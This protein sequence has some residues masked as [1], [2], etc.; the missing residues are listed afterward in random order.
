MNYPGDHRKV[1]NCTGCHTTNTEA[2]TWRS[3]TYKPF[4]AGCHA[5]DY[6][7]G[8]HKKVDNPKILYT[9]GELK[10]C[11]GA[12][13]TYTDNTLSVIKKRR[14]GKHLPSKGGW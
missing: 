3:P 11:S 5:K 4:C 12:C 2:P 10:D 6:K 13:H 8:E 7:A 9:V 1:N 14:S